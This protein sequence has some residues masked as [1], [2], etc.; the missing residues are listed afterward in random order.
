MIIQGLTI[1]AGFTLTPPPT[2]SG[3]IADTYFNYTTVLL[4][5]DGTNN[6][7]NATFVDS[8]TNNFTI[9]RNG[10]TTQGTFSPYGANWS[11]YFDGT[12]D[13][14]GLPS[15]AN[16]TLTGDFTIEF[17]IYL[18][19]LTASQTV[20]N[21]TNGFDRSVQTDGSGAN[22][23]YWDG[24]AN[25][26]IGTPALNTWT[27]IAL[28]RQTST[29][30]GFLN[31][32]QGFSVSDSGTIDFSSGAIGTRQRSPGP[33]GF[34]INGYLSNFRIIK[35]TAVYT[36]AFTPPTAPLTAI[37]N[38][39]LL[40]CADNRLIDDSTNNFAITRNGDVSVQRFSPFSPTA[41]Y[42][43]GTIGGSGYF[44]GTGDYLTIPYSTA[45][46]D[47][48]TTDYTLEAWVFASSWAGWSASTTQ[49]ALIGNF[50]EPGTTNYWCFGP[51]SDGTV[52]F[53]YWNGS[54]SNYV[55]S[56]ATVV[57][58]Q[59]NHIA[60]TKTSSGIILWVNGVGNTV[61]AISGT[62]QSATAQPLTIGKTTTSAGI[63]GYV[64]NLRIVKGTAVYTTNFTPPTAPVTAI[65]N[66]SLLLNYTN[67]G[68]IDNTMMNDLET[69]G[70]A[71]ISTT[72]SKFGVSSMAFDGT[73]DYVVEPTNT[74]FGYGTG[75]FTIEFW[76]YLNT[77]S[78]D[79]TIVSNLS[80]ASSVNPHIYYLNG[81][82]IV[83]YTNSDNRITGSALNT[84]T[85]YHVAV[86]RASGSTKMFINGTQAGST[87]TDSNNYGTTAPLGIGTYWS[88]GSPVTSSTL[89]GYIDD[90]RITKGYARYTAN[91]TAPTAALPTQ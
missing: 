13:Y 58:N 89:N 35:G 2:S 51:H 70:D 34:Y 44:D 48:W 69:V 7:T 37:T 47:W 16:L 84:S 9:T 91:F 36:A 88:A 46:F 3:I 45:A 14:L 22:W 63:T 33:G 49:P 30:K 90:L 24:T 52:K 60:F 42:S 23:I 76:L 29:V 80:S 28:T 86:C 61:T 19:T 83:Y 15:S 1:S 68:I 59:W 18:T 11:N 79:Q 65:T 82:A 67:A 50:A 56:T 53:N 4:S 87:Y 26:T 62:P 85:W 55:T 57:L 74:N 6:A 75:D 32:V 20:F 54:A 12:G 10:N 27:H 25:R 39:S 5:G 43:T 72:Q 41:A 31:G 38:T 21:N 40:T 77:T 81:T 64:S 8:S 17:W 66:T 71:K 73:T 78:V